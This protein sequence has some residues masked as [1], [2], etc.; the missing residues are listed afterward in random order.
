MSIQQFIE[1]LAERLHSSATVSAVFGEPVQAE[2]KVIIPVARIAYGLGAGSGKT[3]LTDR[4]ARIKKKP[5]GQG[6]GGGGGVAVMPLGVFEIDQAQT[7]FVPLRRFSPAWIGAL[8]LGFVLGK[9][10]SRQSS[11]HL[12]RSARQSLK[13]S[14][15]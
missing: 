13:L 5:A 9:L 15:R 8:A 10:F 14:R 7:R 6:G 12:G 1:S 4:G 3:R 11:G 2:G